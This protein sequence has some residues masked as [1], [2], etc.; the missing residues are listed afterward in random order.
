MW[1][2]RPTTLSWGYS[3]VASRSRENAPD[4]QSA[5]SLDPWLTYRPAPADA[6]TR[7]AMSR[8]GPH[9]VAFP[10]RARSARQSITI[11]LGA[12]LASAA[13][14]GALCPVPVAM[15]AAAGAPHRAAICNSISL[16]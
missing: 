2:C 11:S 13:W 16:M 10:R 12:V 15:M 14:Y 1:L 3:L 9:A 6:L 4:D 5:P 8:E 7:R